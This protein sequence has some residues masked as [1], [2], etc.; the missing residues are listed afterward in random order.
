MLLI[1]QGPNWCPWCGGHMGWGGWMMMMLWWVLI[2]AI[3]AAVWWQMRR[4]SWA[5]RPFSGPDRAEGILRER[6]ARGEID[7]ATYRRQLTELKR[8]ES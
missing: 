7:E 6:F 8:S 4:G 1:Q 5:S 3:V 2:L